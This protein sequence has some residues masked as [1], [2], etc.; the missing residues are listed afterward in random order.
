[1]KTLV[2]VIGGATVLSIAFSGCR[3]APEAPRS[4]PSDPG[5][6]ARAGLTDGQ[7]AAAVALARQEIRK[8]DAHVTSATVAI[9]R[10]S[11]AEFNLGYR[12]ESGQV[13]EIKL[14]GTFPH[15]VTTGHPTETQEDFTVHAVLLTADAESGRA[16]LEG[17]Q[18]GAVEPESGAT[19]LAID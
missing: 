2:G 18:T 15:I 8:D 13:L 14:I 19:A 7:Y 4:R 3:G 1:M 9:H 17:V 10:N 11:I 16:C 5:S 12:C 6:K